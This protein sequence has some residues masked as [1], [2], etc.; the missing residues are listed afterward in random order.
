MKQ[1]RVGIIGCGNI[2]QVHMS[3][4][5][6]VR[7]LK[8][9]ASAT[10]NTHRRDQIRRDYAVEVFEDGQKLMESGLVDAV[11]IATPHYS[12]PRYAIA[13]LKRG[14]HV[15]TEKPIAVTAK[16]AAVVEKEHA[17]HPEQVYAAMFQT[18]CSPLWK[19]VKR[20]VSEGQIG[21]VQ[22]F[23]WIVTNWFR[24]QRYYDSSAWRATW[25]DEGGGVLIN[26]CPHNLDTICWVL[27][28]PARVRASVSLGKYHH[29]EVEDE[30]TACLEWENGATGT[31]ITTTGEAP[32]TDRLE[33]AGDRGKLVV[34][35][36]RIKLTQTHQSVSR[37]CKECDEAFGAPRTDRIMIEVDCDTPGHVE[38]TQ[39]FIHAILH[40]EKLICPAR[41]GMWSLELGNA[42][43]MSGLTGESVRIPTPRHKYDR[44]IRELAEKSTFK[45]GKVRKAKV[46]MA[47]SFH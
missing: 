23:S 37:F 20:I 43:L 17:K 22:R 33:I 42:M 10:N 9:T 32:G 2:G 24:T 44:M 14:L 27:G 11:L 35:E 28:S 4:F 8:F 36:G 25:R 29:I 38:L 45:K 19:R 31:F 13:A 12:H 15:L 26:Q 40:G 7:G 5:A 21:E 47:G 34:E 30:V 3:N 1:V 41:E 39:N 46:D 16:A 18:R 6:R